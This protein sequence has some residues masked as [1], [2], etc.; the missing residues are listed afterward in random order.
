LGSGPNKGE[1]ASF[2]K[3]METELSNHGKQENNQS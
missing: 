2:E 3:P 1:K